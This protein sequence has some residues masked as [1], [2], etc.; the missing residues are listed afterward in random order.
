VPEDRSSLIFQY[1]PT[2]LQVLKK[3][4]FDLIVD[5]TIMNGDLEFVETLFRMM[6]WFSY[7][8]TSVETYGEYSHDVTVQMRIRSVKYSWELRM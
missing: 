8:G 3:V 1:R 7:E 6:C 5:C 4:V 2:Y